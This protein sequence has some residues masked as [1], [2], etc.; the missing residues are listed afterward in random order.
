ML[1]WR[2]VDAAATVWLD[3]M[4]R[5]G[6]LGAISAV[7]LLRRAGKLT[8]V[9]L[10]VLAAFTSLGVDLTGWLAAF[11]LGGLA[12]A[13]GAQKTIEHFI[14]SVALVADR[15]VRVGDFCAVDGIMGT[16]EDIGMRS[17]RLRT[18]ERTLVTIPNGIMSSARIE[19]YGSRDQYLF[20]RVLNLRYDTSAD[21]MRE[22]LKRLRHL[23]LSDIRV[24]AEPARVRFV[25]FGP[26]SLDIEIFAYV[27]AI[28][29]DEFL[30]TAEDLHLQILEIIP[31]CGTGFAFPS[32]TV[33]LE[34]AGTLALSR[35]RQ[36]AEEDRPRP[37]AVP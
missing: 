27:A 20:K 22:V 6:Q 23:L 26:S 12:I 32:T 33:Y 11:G 8:V 25:A 4:S 19:N 29:F 7:T 3:S 34:G 2:A 21:Q 1:A 17:T 14:G 36:A 31:E 28:D 35:A 15:P 30:A 37:R 13:L 16:V 18:I 10:A 24:T 9:F 5:R